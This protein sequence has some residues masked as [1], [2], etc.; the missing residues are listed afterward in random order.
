MKNS[1]LKNLRRDEGFT[2][3][4]LMIAMVVSGIVMAALYSAYTVQQQHAKAQEQVTEMQQTLRAG[5]N[6]LIGE[7]RLAGFDPD[8]GLEDKDKIK[9]ATADTFQY[10]FDNDDKN[11]FV[12]SDPDNDNANELRYEI[13]D[14]GLQLVAENIEAIEF[15]YVLEDGTKTSTPGN[16]EDI[17]SV[18]LSVL[19]IA[20]KSDRKFTNT[21]T[22]V[23]ASGIANWDLNG[24]DV[25]GTGNPPNDNYRRRL[26]ITSVKIRNMGL[27]N[28]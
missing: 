17:R 16:L 4:E 12:F 28:E 26:L 21:M 19:A 8:G 6:Y 7:I 23:P 20:N 25:A 11:R 14:G 3:I 9:V 13:H 1:E 10:Y 15:Y 5:V 24:P 27:V 18:E 2:L 22:Y